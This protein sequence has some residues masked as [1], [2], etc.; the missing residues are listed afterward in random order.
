MFRKKL[1]RPKVTKIIEVPSTPQNSKRFWPKGTCAVVG[2]SMFSGLN[3][4]LISNYGSVKVRSFPVG[5]GD[6]MF[7]MLCQY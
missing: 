2:D 4:N 6:D 1:E 5:P 7:L 3:E